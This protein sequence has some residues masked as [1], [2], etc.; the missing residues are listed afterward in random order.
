MRSAKSR[1]TC[2]ILEGFFA[3]SRR[4]GIMR[5]VHS[6]VRS[7]TW[8]SVALLLLGLIAAAPAGAQV[9]AAVGDIVCNSNTA[10]STTCRHRAT[11]DV[12]VAMSP[13]TVLALGDLQYECGELANFQTYYDPTWGRLKAQTR[14]VPGNHEYQTSGCSSTQPGNAAGYF[15]YFN[16]VGQSNGPAGERGKGY[17]SFDIGNWHMIALNSECAKVGGC[18]ATS[19]QGRWLASDLAGRSKNSCIMAYT[20][21]PRYASTGSAVTNLQPLWQQLYDAGAD[22]MLAGHAHVYERFARLGR[23]TGGSA[24][25]TVDPNGIRMFVLGMGGRSL[26]SFTTIRTGSEVRSRTFGVEKLTLNSSGYS[27][28]FMPEAGKTLTDTG[29][30][31]CAGGIPTDTTPPAAPTGLTATAG[32]AQASLDWA[33][34]SE[35]D[36]AGYDVYRSTTSGGPYTK[37]NSAV[38]TTSAYT[39]TGLTNGTTYYYVVRAVDTAN[40]ESANSNQ[41]SATPTGGGGGGTVPAFRAASFAGNATAATLDLPTPSG[42]AAG[43]VMVASVD[44][45]GGPTISAPAGWT[46]VRRDTNLSG[47]TAILSQAAYYKVA[48]ASEPASQTWTFSQ[49]RAASGGI[50]AYSGVDQANPIDAHGGQANA[51]STQVTAPSI[52]TSVAN[53]RLV[54]LFGTSASATTTIAPPGGMSERG[55]AAASAGTTRTTSEGAD[56]TQSTAGATGSRVATAAAAQANV[57]QL[58]ALR[59]GD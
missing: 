51:S 31:S 57:G 55:E 8:L 3:G 48:T 43:D 15:D 53:T 35:S 46:L 36:L 58:I 24:E 30:D 11:S 18:S 49:A 47:T 38:V 29:S 4:G 2:V 42:V 28:Q 26:A 7:G 23:G 19:P 33:N 16:G 10:T 50:Q 22:A 20:H 41:A 12:A 32:D 54:G 40:N 39:D 45:R 6:R 25:P 56:Q 14:P 27:W 17:Y 34:N 5:P 44:V 13:G 37:V 21:R 9:V 52:T 1:V 59:P